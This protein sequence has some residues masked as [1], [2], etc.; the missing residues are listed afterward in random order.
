MSESIFPVLMWSDGRRMITPE[1]SEHGLSKREL[2]AAMMAQH[3]IL[4][5]FA[6]DDVAQSA[7]MYADALIAELAKEKKS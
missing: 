1:P 7:V 3:F 2:F 4:R 5:G 6:K